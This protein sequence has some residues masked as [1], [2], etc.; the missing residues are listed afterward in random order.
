MVY[1]C[2]GTLLQVGSN[3]C[4][5]CIDQTLTYQGSRESQK[6]P[7]SRGQEI[8]KYR[9][10]M[11]LQLSRH[12]LILRTATAAEWQASPYQI[13]C[14]VD[15]NDIFIPRMQNRGKYAMWCKAQP[16]KENSCAF[17]RLAKQPSVKYLWEYYT[18]HGEHSRL[19]CSNFEI[20]SC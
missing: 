4:H 1:S 2:L 15:H 13:N 9:S 18:E 5:H 7:T 8:K 10:Q 12:E 6:R 16:T 3:S 17:S 14:P 20:R 11:V 19:I